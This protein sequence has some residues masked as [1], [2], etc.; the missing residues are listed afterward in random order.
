FIGSTLGVRGRLRRDQIDTVQNVDQFAQAWWQWS[1]RWSLLAGVRHSA[2]RFES[3]DRYI[4]ARNPDD[5]GHRRYQATTPVA[6][7]SFA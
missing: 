7:I 3:D 2:V 6:G 4:T 1:P 5:S